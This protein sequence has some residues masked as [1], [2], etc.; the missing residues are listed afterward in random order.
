MIEV[1]IKYFGMVAE[2][3]GLDEERISTT[4]ENVASLKQELQSRQWLLAELPIRFAVNHE[5]CQDS[6]KL[7]HGDEVALLPPFAGG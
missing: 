1:E 4:A 6:H 7:K 2:R 3:M 5:M